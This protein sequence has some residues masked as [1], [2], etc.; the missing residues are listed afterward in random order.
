MDLKHIVLLVFSFSFLGIVL[1]LVAMWYE[2][3]VVTTATHCGQTCTT[4]TEIAVLIPSFNY[5][6]LMLLVF[7]MFVMSCLATLFIKKIDRPIRLGKV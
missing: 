2:F 5:I 7:I 3:S 1:D 4:G 6:L